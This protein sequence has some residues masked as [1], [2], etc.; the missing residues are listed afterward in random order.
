[1]HFVSF[2]S[3]CRKQIEDCSKSLDKR[4]IILSWNKRKC[5]AL[6][7]IKR[8]FHLNWKID[9]FFIAF[10]KRTK[11]SHSSTEAIVYDCL[12][13]EGTNA[14]TVSRNL[15]FAFYHAL[16]MYPE[17]Q[18]FIVLED[19]L[20]LSPDFYKSVLLVFCMYQLSLIFLV[21][22]RVTQGQF[23]ISLRIKKYLKS[24]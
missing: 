23:L 8:Y 16:E 14:T 18:N 1:M 10:M 17:A 4:C 13:P 7:A 6:I 9:Y 21:L 20:V 12:R 19:D 22:I 5:M 15:R 3:L 24:V 11:I 2:T